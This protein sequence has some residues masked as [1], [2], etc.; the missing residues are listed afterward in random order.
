V[1]TGPTGHLG[2]LIPSDLGGA[3]ERDVIRLRGRGPQ[4]RLLDGL[5]V[6]PGRLQGAT[7]A[8]L[9]I[10][11]AAPVLG[12]NAGLGEVDE[13]FAGEAVV[14]DT[15]DGPFHAGFVPRVAHAG[16]VDDEAARLRVLQEGGGQPWLEGIRAVD[17]GLGVVGDQD[18]EDAVEK[19]PGRLAGLD[20]RRG[21]LAEHR[22]DEPVA[23]EDRGEDPSS[24][25]AAPAG[26][27][28]RQVRHPARVEL[29]LFAGTT[30]G[31]RNGRRGAAKAELG[32][33][34]AAERSIADGDAL[35]PEQLADLGQ[36]HIGAQEPLDNVPLG[37]AHGPA[38]AMRAPRP[39]LDRAD[40]GGQQAVVQLIGTGG[41]GQPVRVRR[42]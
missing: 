36:P 23:G 14:A 15:G 7:V 40:H 18:A 3:P 25:A 8:P 24:E 9:T 19:C 30:V 37:G 2:V 6:L 21:R 12:M 38:V 22:V 32:E 34:E 29:D 11:L 35:A 16:G 4:R 20:R 27:V 31:D 42:P 28:G 41:R 26:G 33:G 17:D 5:E 1:S 39:R 10:V 13:H